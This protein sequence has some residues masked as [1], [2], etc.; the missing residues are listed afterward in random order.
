MFTFVELA[1]VPCID[2][3]LDRPPQSPDAAREAARLTAQARQIM[4]QFGI[5]ALN[6]VG[7]AFVINELMMSWQIDQRAVSI[8]Q[9]TVV[10]LSSR[11]AVDH[12][13][14]HRGC[15]FPNHI[16]G[17][18]APCHPVYSRYDEGWLLFS[19]TN[20]DNS[21]NST[22]SGRSAAKGGA[23]GKPAMWALTQLMTD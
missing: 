11:T 18:D 12:R 2:K 8:E 13:L 16:P 17:H 4:A 15:A 14:H 19:P 7:L 10:L 9:V 1:T 6:G 5:V 20:V 3:E 22:T 21:S 23:S